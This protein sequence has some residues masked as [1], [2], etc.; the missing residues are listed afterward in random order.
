MSSDDA[1]L[2]HPVLSRDGNL[3]AYR[4]SLVKN[5][6]IARGGCTSQRC[7]RSRGPEHN[8]LPR[9]DRPVIGTRR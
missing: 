5:K 8:P 3:D 7:V 9:V 1:I 4:S 6:P 2:C